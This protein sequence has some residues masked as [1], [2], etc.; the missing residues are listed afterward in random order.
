VTL[1]DPHTAFGARVAAH[2]RDDVVAWLTTVA[3]GGTPQP[4]PVWF[5]W[6]GADEVV[7]YSRASQ[8]TTNLAGNPRV[9]LNFPGDDRGGDIVIFSGDARIDPDAPPADEMPA[10][11][12]KYAEHIALQG[13]TPAEF[14]AAYRVAVR[15]TLTRLRGF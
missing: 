8:R 3:P 6:D 15:V 7:V 11:L 12:E 1:V 5:L 13:S 2:L 9:S 4:S 14:A 10:Y